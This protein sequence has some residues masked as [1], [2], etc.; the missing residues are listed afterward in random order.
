MSPHIPLPFGPIPSPVQLKWH[1]LEYYGFL[2]FTANTFTGKEW[3]YGDEDPA[4]F[5][6]TQFDAEKIVSVAS[7]VGM[8]GL[9]LTCKHHDGF[10]LWPSRYTEHSIKNSPYRNGTGDIV[11]EL[12]AACKSQGVK[13]GIYL[14][15]WDRNRADYGAPSYLDYYRNQLRELLENYGPLFE[16]WFDGANGG[17]GYYGGAREERLIDKRLYYNWQATWELVRKLQPHAAIFSDGGPDIRW[18]G[19]ENGIA[20]VPCWATYNRDNFYPGLADTELLNSGERLGTHWAGAECDVSIR[21]GWFYHEEEDS[22]VKKGSEL[23]E[24]YLQSVGRGASL[25]LNVPPDRR[26]LI[27]ENDIRELTLFRKLREMA[28]AKN[29]ALTASRILGPSRGHD[30]QF[31]PENLITSNEATYWATDDGPEPRKVVFEFANPVTF[32]MVGLREHLPLGQRIDKYEVAVEINEAWCTIASGLSIG[33]RRIERTQ[34][35]STQK[36][37]L[38]VIAHGSCPALSEFGLWFCR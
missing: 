20:G 17:Q 12:S 7:G 32:N 14:S 23:F 19:N 24:L 3:G 37:R 35:V 26:G 16:V 15:P 11:G 1:D 25:L 38:R 18:V 30:P 9:I 33:P 13:F 27:C 31:R 5:S 34:T 22:K 2:H 21:P 4:V 6:P 29:I 28:F 36:V 8:K 10:C